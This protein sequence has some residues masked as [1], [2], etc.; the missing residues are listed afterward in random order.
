[1]SPLIVRLEILGNVRVGPVHRNVTQY[2]LMTNTD[3]N[4]EKDR[5]YDGQRDMFRAIFLIYFVKKKS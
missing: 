2:I 5:G 3:V 1:M 4:M